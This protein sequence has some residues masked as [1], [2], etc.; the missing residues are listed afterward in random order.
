MS[1][2]QDGRTG[3]YNSG[4]MPGP[5]IVQTGSGRLNYRKPSR[6]GYNPMRNKMSNVYQRYPYLR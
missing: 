5:V 6:G 1:R 3:A 2:Y 4:A